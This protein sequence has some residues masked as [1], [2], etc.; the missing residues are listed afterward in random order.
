[1]SKRQSLSGT[2]LKAL[3]AANDGVAP[4]KKGE[5]NETYRL[6]LADILMGRKI[7]KP[8]KPYFDE[9]Q[10]KKV[11]GID[12][13]NPKKKKSKLSKTPKVKEDASPVKIS[14]L[15]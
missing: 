1:M 13:P 11:P 4:A 12:E 8:T 10:F 2:E 14:I 7:K 3:T 5:D 6:N 15:R 9:I